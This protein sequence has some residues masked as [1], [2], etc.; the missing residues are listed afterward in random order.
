MAS[1]VPFVAMVMGFKMAVE[2]FIAA[3]SGRD[4]MAAAIPLFEALNWAVA[5]DE[6]LCKD[7]VPDGKDRQPGC[8]TGRPA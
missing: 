5:L 4:P 7:W 3:G 8:G 2:R 6:R 1:T